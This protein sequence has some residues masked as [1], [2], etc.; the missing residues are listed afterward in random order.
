MKSQFI[1]QVA[2]LGLPEDETIDSTQIIFAI[3]LRI[4]LLVE[5]HIKTLVLVLHAPAHGYLL[6]LA[7]IEHRSVRLAPDL[8]QKLVVVVLQEIDVWVVLLS[9]DT[10]VLDLE[11]DWAN[12]LLFTRVIVVSNLV[13]LAQLDRL[14]HFLH[15]LVSLLEFFV[16]LRC[17]IVTILLPAFEGLFH[18]FSGV[19]LLLVSIIIFFVLNTH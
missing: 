10:F 14:G 18:A 17:F 2:F 8:E 1:V 16:Q 19:F 9:Q 13:Q 4:I 7:L 5:K 12:F 6:K 3:V 11:K 15:V